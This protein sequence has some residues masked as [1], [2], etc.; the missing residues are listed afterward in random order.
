MRY[1][2]ARSAAEQHD[3]FETELAAAVAGKPLRMHVGLGPDTDAAL[4][5]IALAHPAVTADMITTA[6]R[7]FAAES[8]STAPSGVAGDPALL[9]DT[10]R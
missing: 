9:P 5:T 2:G 3:T 4:V 10:A 1:I 7:A 8:V 6:R